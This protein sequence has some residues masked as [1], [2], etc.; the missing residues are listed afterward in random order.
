M[1]TITILWF[2]SRFLRLVPLDYFSFIYFLNAIYWALKH[3]LSLFNW[4][5]NYCMFSFPCNHTSRFSRYICE[6]FFF[7]FLVCIV[8]FVYSTFTENIYIF[9]ACIYN[10]VDF[11]LHGY[12]I[13][14]YIFKKKNKMLF[15][16][17]AKHI[18]LS[19]SQCFVSTIWF[20]NVQL[21]RLIHVRYILK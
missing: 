11:I 15:L 16:F 20:F 8:N 12:I 17:N 14:G 10:K 2:V 13:V 21:Y 7:F 19:I 18:I 5:D 3:F 9:L 6:S 1:Y 4:Y